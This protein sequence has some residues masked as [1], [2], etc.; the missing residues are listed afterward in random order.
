LARPHSFSLIDPEHN[1]KFQ[2]K[3]EYSVSQTEWS[4]FDRF[5][6]H[7][8]CAPATEIG[9]TST[10]VASGQGEARTMANSGA[11]DGGDEKEEE[12]EFEVERELH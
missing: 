8:R 5:S 1:L 11:N 12:E 2:G 10:Q 4:N 3:L 6:L 9:P 7:R